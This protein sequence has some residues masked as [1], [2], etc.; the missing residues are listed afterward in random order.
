MSNTSERPRRNLDR[1]VVESCDI[2]LVIGESGGFTVDR[3]PS[4]KRAEE[5][6][7][8]EVRKGMRHVSILDESG[9]GYVKVYPRCRTV[10]NGSD[11]PTLGGHYWCGR[12]NLMSD[13]KC[14][15]HSSGGTPLPAAPEQ[16]ALTVGG[17]Q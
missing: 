10:V 4:L 13:G 1:F 15:D 8:G 16:L 3:F 11:V 17:A 14:P 9:G 5:C 12:T 7:E 2:P 6:A